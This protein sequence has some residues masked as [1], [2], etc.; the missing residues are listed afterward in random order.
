MPYSAVSTYTIQDEINKIRGF[1]EIEPVFNMPGWT[2]TIALT[3]ANDVFTEICGVNFP[4][5]WNETAAPQFYTNSWQQDY[6][7][8]NPNGTSVTNIEWLQ[9]GVAFNINST[10]L[11]KAWVNVEC[12][13]SLP[14]RTGTFS[15]T[16]SQLNDPGFVVSSLPNYS[17]YY[18]VWGQPNVGNA[19]LGNNPQPGSVYTNPL[20]SSVTAASWSSGSGGR[21]TFTLTYLPNGIAVS[22]L[23]NVQG[24]Y[25]AAYN[26]NWTIVSI[27]DGAPAAPTVTVTMTSNPGTYQAGGI[28]NNSAAQS[29]PNNPISQIVDSNGNLL[30]LT[31]YGTEGTTAPTAAN[32]ATPGTTCSGTGATTVWTVVDPNGLGIRI[33]D[34]PSQ[35][36]LV[37]QFNLVGQ[38]PPVAFTS[39]KQ[40]LFPLPNKYEKF[41]RDGLLA[42]AYKYSPNPKTRGKFEDMW[43]FWVASLD[44]PHG[45]REVQDRELEEY[46]FV[47]DRTIFGAARPRGN[48]RGASWP[49]NGP[50][51]C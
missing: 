25:P 47:P 27:N 12:G 16:G 6:A 41:F 20:A 51:N 37:W 42:Q 46:K 13:R 39:M 29:Q 28:I 18:G 7:L 45:L 31:T 21:A 24:V 9:R 22:G 43:K 36:G 33:V 4:H 35:T 19:T 34:V 15:N 50:A 5:K 14:Q 44:G 49:F 8:I 3:M 30:V 40:T 2:N 17:L 26:G 10:S 11:P 38:M 23:L 32:D 1:G 48:W